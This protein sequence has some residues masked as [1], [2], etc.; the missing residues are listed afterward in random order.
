MTFD[1]DS[2]N[3][4]VSKLEAIRDALTASL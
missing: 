3:Y 1:A 4:A 2:V